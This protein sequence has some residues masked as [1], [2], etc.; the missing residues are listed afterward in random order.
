MSDTK[1]KPPLAAV[2]LPAADWI[3]IVHAVE[4]S[5]TRKTKRGEHKKADEMMLIGLSILRQA[6]LRNEPKEE[7]KT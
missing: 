6:G 2:T 1:V 5:F 3:R 4:S 7:S